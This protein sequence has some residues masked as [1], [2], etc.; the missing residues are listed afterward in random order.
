MLV[1]QLPLMIAN[2]YYT[3]T[4]YS[5]AYSCLSNQVFYVIQLGGAVIPH[6]GKCYLERNGSVYIY[7]R[8]KELVSQ[9]HSF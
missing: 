2:N 4:F 9:A 5:I 7:T 3:I 8:S 6:D 1:N